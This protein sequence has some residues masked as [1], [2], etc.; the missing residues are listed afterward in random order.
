MTKGVDGYPGDAA[1]RR[2]AMTLWVRDHV[3][4]AAG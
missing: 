2:L 1:Q 3:D 4:R